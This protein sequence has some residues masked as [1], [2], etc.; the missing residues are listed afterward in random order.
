MNQIDSS[1]TISAETGINT[2]N[3]PHQWSVR[4][5]MKFAS[6]NWDTKL[7][8]FSSFNLKWFIIRVHVKFYGVGKTNPPIN[9][10]ILSVTEDQTFVITWLNLPENEHWLTYFDQEWI[11]LL[12]F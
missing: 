8:E 10:S 1:K 5:G 7:E 11:W 4:Q 2:Q 12:Y 6:F 9:L 3:Q